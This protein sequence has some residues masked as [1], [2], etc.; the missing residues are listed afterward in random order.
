[1]P[2]F[3]HAYSPRNIRYGRLWRLAPPPVEAALAIQERGAEDGRRGL[4]MRLVSAA[5]RPRVRSA[6]PPAAM[7]PAPGGLQSAIPDFNGV[8]C[9]SEFLHAQHKWAQTSDV[10]ILSVSRDVRA[11]QSRW[12]WGG[13]SPS[14]RRLKVDLGSTKKWMPLGDL[15]LG[16]WGAWDSKQVF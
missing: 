14:T 4:P 7:P 13:R 2:G 12:C 16:V 5:Q 6:I 15:G 9:T 1:M 8:P 11:L 3:V 10:F